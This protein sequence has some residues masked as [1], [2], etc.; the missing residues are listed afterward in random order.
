MGQANLTVDFLVKHSD[1]SGAPADKPTIESLRD[2]LHAFRAKILPARHKRISHLDRAAALN[3]GYLGAA[4]DEDWNEFWL[5]LQAFVRIFH[6]RYV[7]GSYNLNINGIAMLTDAE[8][9]IKA[10]QES[11]YFQNLLTDDQTTRKA[12]D[13]AFNSPFY[14]T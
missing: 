5:D 10:L 3:T 8:F 11:T 4:P 6:K 7:D 1:F 9:L 14:N 13:V 2:K 12:A